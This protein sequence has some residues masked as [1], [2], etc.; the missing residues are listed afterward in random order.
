[1]NK[2]G[3]ML[4]IGALGLISLAGCTRN[5]NIKGETIKYSKYSTVQMIAKS[6]TGKIIYYTPYLKASPRV[7]GKDITEV[8]IFKNS[9]Y[10]P[11]RKPF[12]SSRKKDSLVIDRERKNFDYYLSKIDSMDRA[13]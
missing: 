6:D 8:I 13:K 9:E 3:K 10:F 4:G 12:L 11:R 1:M 2:L 7:T 5:Y